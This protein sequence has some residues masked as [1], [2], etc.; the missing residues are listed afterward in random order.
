[1][2]GCLVMAAFLLLVGSVVGLIAYGALALVVVVCFLLWPPLG[3]AVGLL[4]LWMTRTQ[5]KAA[6]AAQSRKL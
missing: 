4:V 1:M 5:W 3:I 6:K 2:E